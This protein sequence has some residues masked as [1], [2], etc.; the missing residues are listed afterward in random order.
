V[1][2]RYIGGFGLITEAKDFTPMVGYREGALST[3][4]DLYLLKL[5]ERGKEGVEETYE[6]VEPTIALRTSFVDEPMYTENLG[7]ARSS[8]T[9]SDVLMKRK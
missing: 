1:R 4:Q 7:S 9:E 8:H 3:M 5:P 2:R 6:D